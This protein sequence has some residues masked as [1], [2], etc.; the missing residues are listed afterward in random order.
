MNLE[1]PEYI[2]TFM[3]GYGAR[4]VIHEPNSVVFP[5]SEG[6]TISPGFE[7]SIGLRMASISRCSSLS[8]INTLYFTVFTCSFESDSRH[9]SVYI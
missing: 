9:G 1:V 3:T 6:I 8:P 5:Q 7:T 2:T 4:L